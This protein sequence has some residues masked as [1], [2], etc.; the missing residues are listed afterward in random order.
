MNLPDSRTIASA[1]L[2]ETIRVWDV[3]SGQQAADALMGHTD[4]V[5]SVVYSPDGQRIVSGSTDGTV[6]VWPA[7]AGP[8]ELCD[9]LT[10]NMS[11][12]QWNEW[13]SPDIDYIKVCPD[14]PM[15]P[16]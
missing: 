8:K 13:V 11:H 15:S 1:S 14:L 7:V 6:R 16:D 2:D 12:K 5:N 9:K 4:D 10:A 3:E